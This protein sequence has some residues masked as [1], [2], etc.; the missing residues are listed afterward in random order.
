MEKA[1]VDQLLFELNRDRMKVR[2]EFSNFW[3]FF[4]FK[5]LS[6]KEKFSKNFISKLFL[7]VSEAAQQLVSFTE[8]H[9]SKDH[10]GRE[11]KG[12]CRRIEYLKRLRS[13]TV[14]YIGMLGNTGVFL[15]EL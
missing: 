7:Q 11:I 10:L 5:N 6:K 15:K 1:V 4:Y 12:T 8:N 3:I 13:Y 9:Q 2:I 14:K